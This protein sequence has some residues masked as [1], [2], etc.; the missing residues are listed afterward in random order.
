MNV[1]FTLSIAL[2][3][4]MLSDMIAGTKFSGLF[5]IPFIAAFFAA[6][7]LSTDY[8]GYGVLLVIFF[9]LAARSRHVNI[10][11][12]AVS[13]CF[14]ARTVIIYV[15][16]YL[17]SLTGIIAIPSLTSWDALQLFAFFAIVPILLYRGKW[18]P[19]F[20]SEAIARIVRYSM[21]LFYPIH[22]LI[23]WAA[24]KFF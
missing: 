16:K 15:I 7:L 22:M 12:T 24:F 20:R 1:M 6:E 19:R 14:A 13:L 21:Y 17:L 18:G 2:V 4:L 8:G 5:F 23:I 3:S 11:R 10:A 9:C